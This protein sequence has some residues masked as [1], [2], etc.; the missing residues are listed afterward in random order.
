M[1]TDLIINMQEI[2]TP[3]DSYTNTIVYEVTIIVDE[4]DGIIDTAT[5]DD[6]LSAKNYMYEMSDAWG[7]RH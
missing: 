7:I 4:I 6:E 5:F 3:L 2:D 1:E